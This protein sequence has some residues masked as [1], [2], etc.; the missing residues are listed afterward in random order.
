MRVEALIGNTP[1]VRLVRLAEPG[2]AEVWVKLEG[3]N[4]GG[5]VKDRP[6]LFMLKRA[7]EEGRLIPGRGQLVVEPTSGNTGIALALLAAVRGYRLVLTMP[8]SMSEERKRIL[9]AY[10]AELVLTPPEGRMRAA[11]EEA[12]RIAEAEGGVV[13]DQFQNP[14]NPEAHY[15]TT[16]P[17]LWRALAGRLDAF[18]YGYGT[19][20]TLSGAGRYLKEQDPEVRVLAV[21]PA[22]APVLSGG[23]PSGKGHGFM[24]M[25]PGFVPKNL[26]TDLLD[27]VIAV[28]EEEAFPLG[29]RLAREE[30][31]FL[32]PSSMANV[33]AALRLAR[34]LGPGRRV[35]TVSPD[36]GYK[37]LSIPPY[38][39]LDG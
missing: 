29:L 1:L 39:A 4:P 35:A 8:A 20:G 7:E 33:A 24:G 2:A 28:P 37:Y 21:E 31:L 30:G 25:G 26:D 5:S 14:A 22:A 17:E 12:Y 32:G 6:A 36:Y 10:G 11:S 19:G 18:V 15:R 16:G 27:G 13:L 9:R 23:K 3:Q 38:N 34:E